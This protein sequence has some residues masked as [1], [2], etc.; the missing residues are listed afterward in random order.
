MPVDLL[1][2]LDVFCKQSHRKRATTI[3]WA[4]NRFLDEEYS[5][6]QPVMTPK[7][8]QRQLEHA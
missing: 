4:L 8:K 5:Q 7:V 6:Q 2:R 1:D 3:Q